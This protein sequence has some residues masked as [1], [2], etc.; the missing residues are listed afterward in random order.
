VNQLFDN[1]FIYFLKVQFKTP[2]EIYVQ[3]VTGPSNDTDKPRDSKQIH[4][5][6]Y[7][8]KKAQ[9]MG[10][11]YNNNVAD[12][13]QQVIT[14]ATDHTF[15][16]NVFIS[17]G[18]PPAAIVYTKEGLDD[19]KC[20]LTNE[21]N[22]VLGV[23]RTF[24]LGEMFVTTIVYKHPALVRKSTGESPLFVGPM[25][26]HGRS[27][28]EDYDSFFSHVANKLCI[29]GSLLF[30]TDGEK[31]MTNAIT[32]CFPN[33]TLLLCTRHLKRNI[34]DFMDKIG[35]ARKERNV[36]INKIFDHGGLLKS[37]DEVTFENAVQTITQSCSNEVQQYICNKLAPSVLSKVLQP[38]WN[39]GTSSHWTNNNTESVNNVLK[40]TT[41]WKLKNIPELLLKLH[42]ICE[43]QDEELLCRSLIDRGDFMVHFKYVHYKIPSHI[44]C[45]MTEELKK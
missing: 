15:V 31:A 23:D 44:W 36:N 12:H 35:I 28:T 8:V 1:N 26:I 5:R 24:N 7:G 41:Q 10:P 38:S 34:K 2:K 22:T 19:L 6:K 29:A 3:S 42:G 18:A 27:L 39:V 16:Q 45:F 21:P 11:C 30:G 4:N 37:A 17:K 25:L 20:V 9:Q 33:A 40:Q 32:R 14:M 13:F 43:L